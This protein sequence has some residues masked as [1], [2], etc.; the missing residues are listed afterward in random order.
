MWLTNV[1]RAFQILCGKA[2]IGPGWTTYELRHSFVSLV[3]GQLDDPV[4]GRRRCGAC[5]HADHAGLSPAVLAALFHSVQ[6]WKRR[7]PADAGTQA[8]HEAEYHKSQEA[9]A[10]RSM[11]TY[12]RSAAPTLVANERRNCEQL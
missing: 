4:K 5:R 11:L 1:R 8:R 12:A 6:A 2:D 3:S 9:T 7:L 10:T